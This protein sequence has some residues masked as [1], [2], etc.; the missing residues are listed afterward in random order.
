MYFTSQH[1]IITFPRDKEEGE[2]RREGEDKGEGEGRRKER[3]M[4]E[5]RRVGYREAED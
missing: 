4:S 1:Q 3:A 5:M 2:G